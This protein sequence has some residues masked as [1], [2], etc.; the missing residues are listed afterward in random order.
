MD[1]KRNNTC[2][3]HIVQIVL[4]QQ[5]LGIILRTY[6]CIFVSLYLDVNKTEEI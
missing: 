3:Y 4:L 5:N 6:I 2:F 1:H